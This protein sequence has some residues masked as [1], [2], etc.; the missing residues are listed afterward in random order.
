MLKAADDSLQSAH[1]PQIANLVYGGRMG[2]KD[3]GDGWKARA[4][5]SRL[6]ARELHQT[7]RRPS[8]GSGGE[9]GTA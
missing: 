1:Q 6:L 3:A 9:P 7:W 2:N 4:G 8:N 5:L